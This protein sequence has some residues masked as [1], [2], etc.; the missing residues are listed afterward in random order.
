MTS[1]TFGPIC[2]IYSSSVWLLPLQIPHS[3]G[4]LFLLTKIRLHVRLATPEEVPWLEAPGTM[5]TVAGWGSSSVEPG[6][7]TVSRLRSTQ[8]PVMSNQVCNDT[9]HYGA[10][11][12]P[13]L[14]K[15][16]YPTMLCAGFDSGGHDSC[17]GDSGVPLFTEINGTGVLIGVV[18]WAVVNNYFCTRSCHPLN[19]SLTVGLCSSISTRCVYQAFFLSRLDL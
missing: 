2:M 16:V 5:L 13:W 6:A 9:Q 7:P 17:L 19:E 8:V 1:M 15:M 3:R 12:P 18:S 10:F 11:S 14:P 4:T